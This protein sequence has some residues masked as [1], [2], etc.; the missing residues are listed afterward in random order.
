MPKT[1][2]TSRRLKI[3]PTPG[4]LVKA[5]I[6]GAGLSLSALARGAGIAPS[7]LSM[8][9]SGD[10]ADSGTQRNIWF[11][12]R[13]LTGIEIGLPAFWGPLLTR[14]EVA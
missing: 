13:A 1:R 12:F 6:I 9:L 4:Q 10:R 5:K 7:T 3:L 8:Y 2:K 14:K 11:A